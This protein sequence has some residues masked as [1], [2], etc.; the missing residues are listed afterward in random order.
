MTNRPR[1]RV[2]WE[3]GCRMKTKWVR[4][5]NTLCMCAESR[6]TDSMIRILMPTKMIRRSKNER[7]G[8]RQANE[9][10]RKGREKGT[11][12]SCSSSEWRVRA[13]HRIQKWAQ[14]LNSANSGAAFDSQHLPIVDVRLLTYKC[15]CVCGALFRALFDS[16]ERA[17]YDPIPTERN[18][19]QFDQFI[20]FKSKIVTNEKSK[21]KL[22]FRFKLSENNIYCWIFTF[23]K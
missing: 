13:E 19:I 16:I 9:R 11:C 21:C 22:S 7:A 18:Q 17:S 1:T 8:G 12:V 20:I 4:V 2:W 15:A 3:S 10:S 6:W 14:T 5:E 23:E